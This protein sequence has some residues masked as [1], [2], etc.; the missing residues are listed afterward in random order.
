MMFSLRAD[1]QEAFAH[2]EFSEGTFFLTLFWTLI[3][4]SLAI[5]SA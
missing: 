1:S 3:M 4:T 5:T 2:W